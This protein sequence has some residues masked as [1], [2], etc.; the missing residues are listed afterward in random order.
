MGRSAISLVTGSGFFNTCLSLLNNQNVDF[1][2]RDRI[3]KSPLSWAAGNGHNEIVELFMRDPGVDKSTEDKDW[4]N[5]I[6]WT[7]S[8]AHI[9]ALNI[10]IQYSCPAVDKEDEKGRTPSNV[11]LRDRQ[12]LDSDKVLV[13]TERVDIEY[14]D[15]NG[16]TALA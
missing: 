5:E 12:S 10:L 3:S 9:D 13:I 11:G 6:P 8:G 15:C 2:L 16:R 7:C 1:N 4:C 14:Q